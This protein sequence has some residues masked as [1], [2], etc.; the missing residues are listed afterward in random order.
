M[1]KSLLLHGVVLLALAAGLWWPRSAPPP[2]PLAIEAVVV[3]QA[4]LEPRRGPIRPRQEPLAAPEPE[5]AG[6]R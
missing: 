4:T 3:D 2:Q 5:P 6:T 1:S